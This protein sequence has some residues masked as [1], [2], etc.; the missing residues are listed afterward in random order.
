MV[1]EEPKVAEGESFGAAPKFAKLPSVNTLLFSDCRLNK[2]NSG[3][4]SSGT[5]RGEAAAVERTFEDGGLQF[6]RMC[7]AA[8]DAKTSALEWTASPK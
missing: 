5:T 3:F 6:P 1:P 2:S 7:C 8:L 4:W